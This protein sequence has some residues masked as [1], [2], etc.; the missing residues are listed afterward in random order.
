MSSTPDD[1]PQRATA[2]QMANR[3]IKDIRRRPRAPGAPSGSASASF[4]GPFSS[5][6]PN[7]VSSTSAGSQPATNGFNFGQSQ[8]FPPAASTPKPPTQ[9]GGPQFAFGGGGGSPAFNFSGSFG[10]SAQTPAANPF[11]SMN[12]GASQQPVGSNFSGFQGNMFNI[13]PAVSQSPAQQPLPSGGMFGAAS[14][15]SSSTG[16]LFGSTATTGPSSQSGTTT[17]PN[18]SIFGQSSTGAPSTNFNQPGSEKP[19]PFVQT[20]GF[21]NDSMQTSPDAK[22]AAQK[23]PIFS[24]GSGGFG[25]PTN[26]GGPGTGNLFGGTS[27]APSQIP[28]KPLFGAKSTDQAAARTPLFGTTTQPTFSAS[29]P[30]P[31]SAAPSTTS[32]TGTAGSSLFSTSTPK[33]AAALQ[34]PFQS[35][36][37]FG[38]P[39]SPTTQK[40]NGDKGNEETKVTQPTSSQPSITFPPATAGA[41]H[42][43]KEPSASPSQPSTLFRP[44]STGNLF[45]AKPASSTEQEKPKPAEGNPFS[46]LFVP[47]P[48]AAAES[49]SAVQKPLPSSNLFASKPAAGDVTKANEPAKQATPSSPFPASTAAKPSSIAPKPTGFSLSTPQT[50]APTP[51]F[52]PS[53]TTSQSPFGTH[54]AKPAAAA[55]SNSAPSAPLQTFDKLKPAKIPSDIGGRTGEEVEMANRVRVLNECFRRE[56][57][58]VDLTKENFDALVLHYLRVRETIGSPLEGAG[59][60][61]KPSDD[62]DAAADPRPPKK[63]KPFGTTDGPSS[64]AASSFTPSAPSP[65]QSF[66]A[67]QSGSTTGSKRKA[68]EDTG[69]DTPSTQQ[70]VKRING[71]STTASIFANS[72]TKSKTSESDITK[73][74]ESAKE[75]DTP[76]F[77]PATPEATKPSLFTTTPT[78]S[79]PKQ[80]FSISG[81][82]EASTSDATL[83]QS[84][85]SFKPSS[86]ALASSA[87]PANPFTLKATSDKDDGPSSTPLAIPKFSSSGTNFFAQFK[88]QS[89]KEAEKEKQKRK[90]EDFDSD[91]E[92]EAEWER[93][94]AENQ[95]RKREEVEAQQA[96]RAKFI[97]GQGFSFEDEN[98]G[99][100]AEKSDASPSSSMA[101]NSVFEAKPSSLGKSS[102]I[103][104]H[105]SA[106]PSENGE[107][108]DDEADDTEEA[109]TSGDDAARESSFAP[110]EDL[111]A[112]NTESKTNGVGGSSTPES[113]DEGDFANA[114]KKSKQTDSSHLSTNGAAG[115]QGP[116]GRSLFDR[117]Q[118]D[119]DGKPKR[120]GEDEKTISSLFSSSKYAS[121][122]NSAGSA[123]NPFAPI[124]QPQTD[125]ADDRTASKPA[126]TNIF[127]SSTSTPNPFGASTSGTS[128]SSLFTAST[129]KPGSDNTWKLNTPIK[130]APEPAKTADPTTKPDSESTALVSDS[131]KPFSALFGS[132]SA[133]PKPGSNEQQSLGF[134]FGSPSQPSS[135][136]LTPSVLTSGT[137]SRASTPGAASDAAADESTADGEAAEPLPQVDL[138]RGGA[139]EENEDLVFEARARALKFTTI[140][141]PPDSPPNTPKGTWDSQ[142]VGYIRILKDR[143]TSRGRMLL[144]A[145]PSGKVVLN[146][147]LFKEIEYTICG[148]SVQFLNPQPSGRPVKWAIRVRPDVVDQLRAAMEA[149]KS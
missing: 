83:S 106:T 77:K 3:R 69:G 92:D 8:S 112:S 10:G 40:P 1:K 51:A 20:T 17:P 91:E 129:A 39:T 56:I 32:T 109:S 31:S 132:T 5:I 2:A 145:D 82:K 105:L 14:Q 61:R 25:A 16:P 114:L 63:V 107:N 88:A 111:E 146:A 116:G 73:D 12:T 81:T 131:S 122:F 130:F 98:D 28:S 26:F 75:L 119:Q 21:G 54:K 115:E 135:S 33:S 48:A 47:K 125:K 66:G 96:R 60:K 123:P 13:P 62:N 118:Y 37:L 6:D 76:S 110:T 104:G 78:S 57:A 95:R 139:G 97:P 117:V 93:K 53:T 113:S 38:A 65:G 100:D 140:E 29:T 103:F 55:S 148:N 52:P 70:S 27:S 11:A 59:T 120:Q 143:T 58:K 85:P 24:S 45:A 147:S 80:L 87:D 50:A 43:S 124:G 134:T 137:P 49:P 144:R 126:P 15:P 142:G 74:A 99:A 4:G 67:H 138:A 149:T 42:F 18:G 68:T 7:T 79:P 121:S 141:P 44:P 23:P 133:G 22:S 19:N 9:N 41:A 136:F 94:D 108:E 64:P 84:M 46:S 34:S 101:G 30:T 71:G 102:N 89:D 86:T 36:S 72:F 127:G 35:T 90:A 128:T